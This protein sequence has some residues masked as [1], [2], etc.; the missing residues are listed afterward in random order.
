METKPLINSA[1]VQ[2]VFLDCLCREDISNQITVDGIE[3]N[4]GFIPVKIEDNREAIKGML[5]NLPMEFRDVDEKGGGGW[6][7]LNACNDK[8]GNQWTG[9]HELMEKL[10]CL[11]IAAGYVTL[12]M[13]RELWSVLPGGMP[14]YTIKIRS[15]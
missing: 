8:N 3:H 11:G 13:P 12:L 15:Y 2:E 6:S 14:Y 4:F 10:F 9:F 5:K 1:K 7:F